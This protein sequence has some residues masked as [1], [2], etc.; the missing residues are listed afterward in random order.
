MI[1]IP[2]PGLYK[3]HLNLKKTNPACSVSPRIDKQ[4]GYA[5]QLQAKNKLTSATTMPK[6]IFAT[7]PATFEKTSS[8]AFKPWIVSDSSLSTVS[9]VSADFYFW[10]DKD[11]LPPSGK[12]QFRLEVTATGK[13][14]VS[15][16]KGE[17]G[18]TGFVAATPT[19]LKNHSPVTGSFNVEYTVP[20][21]A[22]LADKFD[23]NGSPVPYSILSLPSLMQS[24]MAYSVIETPVFKLTNKKGAYEPPLLTYFVANA[25]RLSSQDAPLTNNGAAPKD[26]VQK[27]VNPNTWIY[28]EV[29]SKEYGQTEECF[30]IALNGASV[31]SR[32]KAVRYYSWDMPAQGYNG[33]E[34]FDVINPP[35]GSYLTV[36]S[37][38]PISTGVAS[39]ELLTTRGILKDARLIAGDDL[40]NE[41]VVAIR[42]AAPMKWTYVAELIKIAVSDQAET[43]NDAD[44]VDFGEFSLLTTSILSEPLGERE[45]ELGPDQ[46]HSRSMPFPIV[47]NEDRPHNFGM[48]PLGNK[49]GDPVNNAGA[50]TYP[51]MP[52]FVMDYDTLSQYDRLVLNLVMTEHDKLTFWQ[53]NGAV[54][55]AFS[56]FLA[57][58]GATAVSG[59]DAK[60]L[61]KSIYDFA[62]TDL[63]PNPKV[64]DF[65]GNAAIILYKDADSDK[66]TASDFGLKGD[67]A[68][69]FSVVGPADSTCFDMTSDNNN[70][71]QA[72]V[73]TSSTAAT[74]EISLP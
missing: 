26:L 27:A 67:S 61:A 40:R 38:N 4:S 50:T 66:D 54:I 42:N 43:S 63:N 58:L 46:I 14:S 9:P 18:D 41:V 11:S 1:D 48:R 20:Y 6:T 29:L 30:S 32:A 55:K 36:V 47:D 33:S 28:K 60:G 69:Y 16:S 65:M 25:E 34:L 37:N 19:A 74:R 57:E 15:G 35:L 23:I 56:N 62:K 45:I 70:G 8:G 13:N 72:E 71:H 21:K 51:Q 31:C 7:E 39:L 5:Y 49:G 52:V 53:E 12:L 10:V 73:S 24:G 59:V 68:A 3:I 64:H 44:D 2:E 17:I 22:T